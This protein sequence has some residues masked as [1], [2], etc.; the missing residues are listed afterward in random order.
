MNHEAVQKTVQKHS[1]CERKSEFCG[2]QWL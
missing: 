2:N 1:I